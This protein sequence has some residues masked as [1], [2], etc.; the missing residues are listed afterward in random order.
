MRMGGKDRHGMGMGM[1][2]G[3]GMGT[4]FLVGIVTRGQ[5]AIVFNYKGHFRFK[6]FLGLRVARHLHRLPR[7]VMPFWWSWMGL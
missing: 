5:D 7:E 4:D 1:T 6:N 2:T 3:T